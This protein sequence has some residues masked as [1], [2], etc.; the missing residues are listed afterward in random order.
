[1][2]KFYTGIGS[3]NV[4][5]DIGY[6]IADIA[7]NLSNIGYRLR[8]G[9]ADGCD[10]WFQQ[11]A[12]RRQD[13]VYP[14]MD[15]YIAWNGF[16]NLRDNG[17]TIHC[18]SGWDNWKEA[19]KIASEIHPNWN[20]CSRGAKA[21]HTRNVYQVLGKDLDNPSS[22]LICFA[23]SMGDSVQGGTRTAWEIARLFGVPCFNLDNFNDRERIKAWLHP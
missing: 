8:S 17:N 23:P 12:E 6:L 7:I 18:P 14:D 9:G 16:N 21:L 2:T 19:E 20:A 11:G 15:I 5:E 22:F 13:I 10:S 1:M 4:P 3:R